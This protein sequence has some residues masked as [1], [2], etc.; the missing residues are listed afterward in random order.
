MHRARTNKILH[1]SIAGERSTPYTSPLGD[2]GIRYA[3]FWGDLAPSK[4]P[5]T[6][7]KWRLS[8]E[9]RETRVGEFGRIWWFWG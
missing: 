2:E 9:K 6:H 8:S 1:K 5:A 3:F 7:K 4:Y